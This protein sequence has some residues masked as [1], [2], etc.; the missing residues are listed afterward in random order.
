MYIRTNGIPSIVYSATCVYIIAP[1]VNSA[2]A[3]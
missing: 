1:F 2:T 3:V